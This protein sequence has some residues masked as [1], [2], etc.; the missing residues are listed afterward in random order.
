MSG[1]EFKA[2]ILLEVYPVLLPVLLQALL[3]FVL[4]GLAFTARSK[5][6]KSGQA[7]PRAAALDTNAYPEQA[8][9][10]A[11]ALNNQFE[12]P[13]YFFAVS[14]IAMMLQLQDLWI[15]LAAWVYIAA[16]VVHA[17][18]YL[19]SNGLQTRALVFAVGLG[20]LLVMWI[21]LAVHVLF[22]GAAV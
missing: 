11:G 22:A 15:V 16:R 1:R 21:R 3:L 17:A 6:L 7:D 5:A 8:R 4:G 12:T 10:A 2:M 9:K 20:A 14:I 13:V 18:I 19:T